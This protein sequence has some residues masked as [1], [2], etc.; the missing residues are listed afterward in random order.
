MHFIVYGFVQYFI[1]VIVAICAICFFFFCAP[2]CVF[3]FLWWL[4]DWRL[5]S[6]ARNLTNT[7]GIIIIIIIIIITVNKKAF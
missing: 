3:V 1:C 5:C 4:Q 2:F 6:T 7:Y